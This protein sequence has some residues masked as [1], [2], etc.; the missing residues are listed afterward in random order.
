VALAGS[1]DAVASLLSKAGVAAA[2]GNGPANATRRVDLKTPIPVV[3]L[4]AS[5]WL[6]PAGGVVFG[7]DP[8]GL[9]LP[10]FRKLTAM[11]NS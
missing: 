9:D 2:S 5:V 11:P 8:L 3:V 7:P 1:D 6:D 10:L 4:Y